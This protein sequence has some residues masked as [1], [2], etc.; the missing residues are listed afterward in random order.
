MSDCPYQWKDYTP[1]HNGQTFFPPLTLTSYKHILPWR[2]PV[3]IYTFNFM[4]VDFSFYSGPV[5]NVVWPK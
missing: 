5:T 1:F 2:D 3:S 4:S